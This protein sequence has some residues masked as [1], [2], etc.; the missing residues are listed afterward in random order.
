MPALRVGMAHGSG[1]GTP[2]WA[3][4]GGGWC[5]A[6]VLGRWGGEV[7][8]VCWES[9]KICGLYLVSLGCLRRHG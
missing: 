2:E 1:H 5:G 9:A 3:W 7:V 4:H 8:T 6:R